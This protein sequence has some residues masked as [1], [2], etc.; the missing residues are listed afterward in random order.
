MFLAGIQSVKNIYIYFNS[1]RKGKTMQKTSMEQLHTIIKAIQPSNKTYSDQCNAY[2]DTLVKPVGSLGKLEQ[3]A[4]KLAAIQE[5]HLPRI[6]KKVTI[7]M[8]GDNG[9]LEEGIAT[10]PQELT[11]KVALCMAKGLAG[12]SALSK[13]NGADVSVYNIGIKGDVSHPKLHDIKIAD[14]TKNLL[15]EAAMTEDEVCR[16]ILAGITSVKDHKELGYSILGTGEMGI[17]NTTTSSAIIMALLDLSADD[18]V[19][20]GAGLSDAGLVTKKRV[21]TEALKKHRLIG[22][23]PLEILRCV[24]GLDIAGLVGVFLG[25]AYYKLPVVIDGVIS[26]AAALVAYE[27]APSTA[28]YMFTSHCAVE[29]AYHYVVKHLDISPILQLDMRLGEGSGCPL[30]FGIMEA[31][32]EMVRSIIPFKDIDVETDYMVDLRKDV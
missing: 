3:M 26:S 6:T 10:S 24:G 20:K 17:G 2:M 25:S 27:L 4:A 29:P 32:C 18:A 23:N 11:P 12:V 21:I 8:A 14:G 30:A 9:V 22:A 31:A 5:H 7:V 13:S 28:D 19:G 16:A 1:P 15:K